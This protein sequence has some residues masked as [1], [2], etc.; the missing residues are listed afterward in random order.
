MRKIPTLFLR[1]F[2][3]RPAL[4]T[5]EP[6]PECTWVLNG[7]G[8]ATRKWDGTCTMFDA[9][10]EWWA[11]REVKPGKTP[12]PRF[13]PVSTDEETGKIVG[14]EPASQ[15][16]FAKIHAEAVANTVVDGPGTYEL[17]GPK[18]NLNPERF[19]WPALI[20][21]GWSKPNERLEIE[22]AP[23]DYEGLRNWLS[24]HSYEGLVFHHLD[25]RM[26]KIKRRDFP[27]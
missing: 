1:D 8:S 10:G 7:E 11:R 21:H 22:S 5:P 2:N 12:P 6:N 27:A 18:I 15:S 16:S 24:K 14:W 20:A 3:A 13:V 25:G 17:V 26:A 23:R 4:V 19:A 9:S